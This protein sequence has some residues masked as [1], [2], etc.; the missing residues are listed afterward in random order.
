MFKN[1]CTLTKSYLNFSE[2][3]IKTIREERKKEVIR[4]IFYFL[5]KII[6][7][8]L[9]TFENLGVKTVINHVAHNSSKQVVLF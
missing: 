4:C 8:C 6:N 5:G 2:H 3:E 9:M 7:D 1:A